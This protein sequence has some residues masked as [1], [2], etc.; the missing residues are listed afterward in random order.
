M[1]RESIED[2]PLAKLIHISRAILSA[3]NWCEATNVI[4]N[5]LGELVQI[6]RASLVAV[7]KLNKVISVS[8]SAS[9]A[10]DNRYAGA[11]KELSKQYGNA[12]EPCIVPAT[13]NIGPT[14]PSCLEWLQKQMGGTEVIWLPLTITFGKERVA[15]GHALLLE[16][17][18]GLHWQEE[19][20]QL[21]TYLVPFISHA[22][23]R[24]YRRTSP[25]AKKLFIS[26]LAMAFLI[27]LF[28]PI[29]ASLVAPGL[30]VPEKPHYIFAPFDGILKSLLV[31]PGQIVKK[32][33][34]LF[35]YE[36]RVLDKQLEE[37]RQQI[38]VARAEL[39]RLESSGF[40]DAES[41]GKIPVQQLEVNKAAA[42]V[43]FYTEQRK[44]A[45]VT[46]ATD[47]IVVLDDPDSLIGAN[48]QTGQLVMTI[49]DPNFTKFK[50]MVPVSDSGLLKWGA[51]VKVRLD[52]NPLTEIHARVSHIGFDVKLSEEQ[53]PSVL[54]E[55]TWVN[56]PTSIQPGQRG[57]AKIFA[58]KTRLGL[59][60]FRR[61]LVVLRRLTG[62]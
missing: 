17:W 44:R 3:R 1:T 33:T 40:D 23:K 46:T 6:D 39:F 16:R 11:V 34:V 27:M 50:I 29:D 62:F 13:K 54:V 26:N 10:Q 53:I 35:Q 45:D 51:A 58:E 61:P 37:S 14:L 7:K 49:A 48:L 12:L 56:P 47:G 59:Q 31:V 25:Y 20:L 57:T 2:K 52:K 8:S 55:A 43:A 38:G 4:V 32:N 21:L 15:I 41:Q 30:V 19:E 24:S 5:R 60:F 42:D 22:L 18:R 28:I 36:P 9:P